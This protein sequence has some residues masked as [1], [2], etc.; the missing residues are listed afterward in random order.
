VRREIQYAHDCGKPIIPVRL[1]DVQGPILL[2]TRQWLTPDEALGEK[3][4]ARLEDSSSEDRRPRRLGRR[5][6]V[7][8]LAILGGILGV[9]LGSL[10]VVHYSHSLDELSQKAAQRALEEEVEQRTRS[11]FLEV[12]DLRAELIMNALSRPK[13]EELQLRIRTLH[14]QNRHAIQ[15]GNIP[16]SHELTA[17]IREALQACDIIVQ[18]NY[19]L[20][21]EQGAWTHAEAVP[22]GAKLTEVYPYFGNGHQHGLQSERSGT[23][24]SSADDLRHVGPPTPQPYLAPD[25]AVDLPSE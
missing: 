7:Q 8:S 23:A 6:P 9:L 22:R 10:W 16:L 18:V 17:Q 15:R 14:E 11:D 19:K 12:L 20:A 2:K 1:A 13:D 4:L 24:A 3:I 25:D 21:L 5:S